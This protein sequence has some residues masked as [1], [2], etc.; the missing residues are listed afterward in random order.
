MYMN[1]IESYMSI[2]QMICF[3]NF[4]IPYCRSSGA[5]GRGG[6]GVEQ[7]WRGGQFVATGEL[8]GR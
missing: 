2:C 7:W 3:Y 1:Y 6:E 8:T 5:S 4:M